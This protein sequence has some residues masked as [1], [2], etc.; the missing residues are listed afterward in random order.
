MK[1]GIDCRIYGPKHTGIGRYVK[2]LVENL[3]K[4]D[5]TNQYVLFVNQDFEEEALKKNFAN[6]KIVL[7]NLPHYSLKE[8]L[9]FP[10]LIKKEKIDFMHFPHFNVPIFYKNDYVVTIHD[11]IKHQSKGTAT[12]TRSPVFYWFKYLGY[13]LVFDQAVKKAKKIITPSLYVKEQIIKQY[14]IEPNK[15]KVTYEGV[16]SRLVDKGK[17]KSPIKVNKPYFLYVGSVYPHKNIEKLIEAVKETNRRLVIVCAR[18]VFSQRLNNFIVHHEAEKL[19]TL[20]GFVTDDQLADLYKQALAFIFPTL[21]EGFGL[22]GLE[23]MS[24]GC[25][26]L[27]SDIAVLKEVYGE[28]AW[29]FNPNNVSQIAQEIIKFEKSDKKNVM[30]EKGLETVKKYSWQKTAQ[31]T[32]SVYENN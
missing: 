30:V 12:T 20:T 6:L 23:A 15:I 22:P 10:S 19:V 21:S 8:Q 28:A 9:F 13:K 1:I 25:P 29:Y 7:V 5:S 3:L 24:L 16:D 14:K 11:L 18:N 32:L 27:C 31:E 17:P 2:N 26:V 4:L